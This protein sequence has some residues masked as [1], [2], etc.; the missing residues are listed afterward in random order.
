MG[1][2]KCLYINTMGRELTQRDLAPKANRLLRDFEKQLF[3][4]AAKI[5]VLG[6][7]MEGL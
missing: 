7:F 2:D 5:Q 3:Q 6:K 4:I 1:L